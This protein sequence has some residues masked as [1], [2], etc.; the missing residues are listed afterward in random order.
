MSRTPVKSAPDSAGAPDR[1]FDPKVVARAE[2]LASRY[3]IKVK[4][5]APSAYVGTVTSL[6]T[7]FGCGTSKGA[8]VE[9]TRELLK[10]ALAYLLEKGRTPPAPDYK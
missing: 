7:V 10:W 6:P 8:A 4:K 3:Q 5:D 9:K 1:P 2:A